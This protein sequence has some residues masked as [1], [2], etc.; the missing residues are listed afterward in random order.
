MNKIFKDWCDENIDFEK[1]TVRSTDFPVSVAIH[2]MAGRTFRG[3]LLDNDCNVACRFAAG[4][5]LVGIIQDD[6]FNVR[7][8]F[9]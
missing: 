1:D 6:P 8:F 9:V 5:E 4:L 3:I 7:Y 2:N